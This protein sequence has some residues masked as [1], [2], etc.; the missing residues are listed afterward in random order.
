MKALAG[1]CSFRVLQGFGGG[2]LAPSEQSILAD[3][4][5]PAQRGMA[6]A[7]YGLAVVMAPAIGPTLGGWITDNYNWRWI[8]FINIPVGILSLFLSYH[9]V[10]W[11]SANAIKEKAAAW[12]GGL[13]IDYI[14]FGCLVDLGNRRVAG[15]LRQRARRMTGSAQTSSGFSPPL[16]SPASSPPSSG[17]CF[18]TDKPVVDL[19]LFKSRNFPLHQYPDVLRRLRPDIDNCHDSAV[20]A[21]LARLQRD[22][23]R[24]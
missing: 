5:A 13:R 3:T 10:H 24:P 17:N 23:R 1:F 11:N 18:F 21:G 22:K 14:G 20:R 2:G 19:R 6:F 9:M 4:F 8:F 16:P 15:H 12:K 7:V